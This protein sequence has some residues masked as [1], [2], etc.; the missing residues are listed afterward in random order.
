MPWSPNVRYDGSL[1]EQ[2]TDAMF[3]VDQRGVIVGLNPAAERISGWS[4]QELLNQIPF[5]EICCGIADSYVEATCEN[6]FACQTSMTS[7]EMR[8]R[9]KD[10]AEKVLAASST[11]LE[12]R[13]SRLLIIL[14]RDLS[15]QQKTERERYHRTLT[16]Q[17]IQAQEEERKRISRDLHDS[18][19]QSLYSI[20]IGLRVLEQFDLDAEKKSFLQEVI[21]ST[22]RALEEV[23]NLA[24]EL[25]PATL[26]DLGLVP[27]LRSHMRRYEQ[28]YGIRTH[29]E[30]LGEVKRYDC[31]IET[32][33]YRIC[34]EALTNTAKYANA[35]EVRVMLQMSDDQLILRYED[36]GIGFDVETKKRETKGLG[37]YG[38]WER[39]ELFHGDLVV[40]SKIGA[41][42]KIVVRIPLSG[43]GETR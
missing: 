17:I 38:M 37:L 7:F 10:G 22:T 11:R 4:A 1:F 42:T 18:T 6:C 21:A 19:G 14:L 9:T 2:I 13:D 30:V 41:G 16:K 26:D 25:R 24:V 29:F 40:Q 39:V 32:G 34:Q 8:L 20:L 43:E 12:E 36:D 5:C 35:K 33:L 28:V 23:K 15:L 3:V 31:T 27:A